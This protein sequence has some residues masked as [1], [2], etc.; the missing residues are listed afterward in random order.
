MRVTD[1]LLFYN[2]TRF[3]VAYGVF[4]GKGSFVVVTNSCGRVGLFLQNL[5]VPPDC[6]FCY[7][8]FILLF[9]LFYIFYLYLFVLIPYVM[10]LNFLKQ[11]TKTPLNM[12]KKINETVKNKESTRERTKERKRKRKEKRVESLI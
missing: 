9:L 3:S 11:N 12:V 5:H 8:V 7:D 4:N 6:L 10:S 2:H 1:Q